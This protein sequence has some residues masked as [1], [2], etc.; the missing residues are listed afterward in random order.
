MTLV[1]A[2]L[3]DREWRLPAW[4]NRVLPN[5]DIEGDSLSKQLKT[6]HPRPDLQTEREVL[7][8]GE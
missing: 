3:G 1:P 8:S 6:Q 2:L 7:A 5:V 4:L